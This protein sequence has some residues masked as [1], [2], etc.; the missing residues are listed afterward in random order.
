MNGEENEVKKIVT[1]IKQQASSQEWQANKEKP[2]NFPAE[3]RS[4]NDEATLTPSDDDHE[5]D[6]TQYS[7]DEEEPREVEET[8]LEATT[9]VAEPGAARRRSTRPNKGKK[10]TG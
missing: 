1:S 9:P 2:E 4:A 7:S 5:T 3:R 8:M 10:I 6:V